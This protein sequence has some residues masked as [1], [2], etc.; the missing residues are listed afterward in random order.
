MMYHQAVTWAQLT[1]ATPSLE[2]Y[3]GQDV[4]YFIMSRDV[5]CVTS[6][7][8]IEMT[9]LLNLE[10]CLNGVDMKSAAPDLHDVTCPRNS[11][12]NAQEAECNVPDNVPK[13]SGTVPIIGRSIMDVV[14]TRMGYVVNYGSLSVFIYISGEK[15]YTDVITP[16]AGISQE[17]HE[18]APQR[19]CG[20]Q[21]TLFRHHPDNSHVFIFE[22]VSTDIGFG[23]YPVALTKA[24]LANC[25][26]YNDD[27]SSCVSVAVCGWCS[28]EIRCTM[29]AECMSGEWLQAEAASFYEYP[30]RQ[31]HRSCLYID[32]V[33]SYNLTFSPRSGLRISTTKML[34][35]VTTEKALNVTD[36][37]LSVYISNHLICPITY[38]IQDQSFKFDILP[39]V[40]NYS[41]QCNVSSSEIPEEQGIV[42]VQYTDSK[43]RPAT[44]WLNSTEEIEFVVPTFKSFSP[45]KG[46]QAGGTLLE[47]SGTHLL[48]GNY[49]DVVIAGR[50]CE[51]IMD[52]STDERLVCLTPEVAKPTQSLVFINLYDDFTLA[53]LRRFT[54]TENPFIDSIFPLR[55]FVGG[56]E[57]QYVKGTNLDSIARPLF[58][59][60]V[61]VNGTAD[62]KLETECKVK[63]STFMAC[64][65]PTIV[66]SG[67]LNGTRGRRSIDNSDNECNE[68]TTTSSGESV[69]FR[70]G[71]V[72]DNVQEWLPSVIQDHLD[73]KYTTIT[74][75]RDPVYYMF[76]GAGNIIFYNPG[77]NDF[78][79]IKG[80]RLDCGATRND[81]TIEVGLAYCTPIISL[82]R[83]QLTC[84]PPSS[85]PPVRSE[86][87][88][89]HGFPHVLVQVGVGDS[90][91]LIG[92]I[93]YEDTKLPIEAWIIA[94]AVGVIFL[95]LFAVGVVIY[96]VV[97]RIDDVWKESAV[98]KRSPAKQNTRP[99][100]LL[101]GPTRVFPSMEAQLTYI[102][103]A[104]TRGR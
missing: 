94:I 13:I 88:E 15:I 20:I 79:V 83:T 95:V 54:Y 45:L 12:V 61:Y 76:G 22:N 75:A 4:L 103:A 37:V 64:P 71:F 25:T 90:R 92:Y 68:I 6:M 38:F 7:N 34:I 18:D 46:P 96:F 57:F 23:G 24:L 21:T 89:S 70:I 30:K 29:E 99:C 87:L 65:S 56:G 3:V 47:I 69:E 84:T 35:Y 8:D 49:H 104:K 77:E 2:M 50:T 55:T 16:A 74:V 58:V 101:P 73:A 51:L 36:A 97:C 81:I 17:F 10:M 59:V 1:T 9:F 63:N 91:Y 43:I 60:V 48:S 100:G 52:Y 41:L 67:L 39:D 19:G 78:L 14:D 85:E 31:I 28:G 26:L 42:S 98:N 102:L 62:D 5:L 40:W 33:G 11:E 53:S 27:C 32:I 66:I 72:L 80:E 44:L 93:D 82:Y 86:Y